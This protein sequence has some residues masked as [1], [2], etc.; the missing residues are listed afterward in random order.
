MKSEFFKV[1]ILSP[2]HIGSG[3]TVDAFGY[4]VEANGDE[5]LCHFV[6]TGAWAAEY[7]DPEALAKAYSS[8]SVA[9]MRAFMVADLDPELYAERS[10]RVVNNDLIR[11]FQAK[12]IDPNNQLL[13]S[14]NL[15][16]GGGGPLLPG[17][18]LKGA[19]RTAVIDW[20][21]REQGLNLKQCR[22]SREQGEKLERFIGKITDNS[23]Q[24]LKVADCEA[25]LGTS[26]VVMAKE[27]RRNPDKNVTPKADCEVL[28]SRLLGDQPRAALATR[29][30][31]GR[32]REKSS[33]LSLKNGQSLDWLQLCELVNNYSRT[34]YQKEQHKFWNLEHFAPTQQALA[35]IEPLILN[36][37]AGAMVLKVGHYSQ[38]EYVTVESNKPQTRRAKDG[39][40]LP[41]GTT[42]TLA[43]G[44]YP[45]GWVLLQPCNED[46]YRQLLNERDSHNS[47]LRQQQVQKR[48]ARQKA[49]AEK[50]EQ[51]R[52]R[53]AE[54][55]RQ[56]REREEKAREEAAKPWLAAVRRLSGQ[57]DWG[58][59]KQ[60]LENEELAKYRNQPEFAHAVL[61]TAE[62]LR[63]L[64]PDK[65]TDDRHQQVNDWLGSCGLAMA[66]TQEEES[67]DQRPEDCTL[68]E[69]LNEFGDFQNS[70]I[71][72]EELT[73][74]ALALL[75]QKMKAWGCDRRKAKKNKANAYQK[76]CMLMQK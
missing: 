62:K 17:S 26:L 47:T 29:I 43:D 74:E 21:D 42:R 66:A 11:K 41:H 70:T 14:P 65:W 2:V 5:G 71:K 76:V 57:S 39:G 32:P 28:A 13:L 49:A 72:L 69:G 37:P 45:F 54:Q 33:T 40:N 30:A 10:C 64:R 25:A 31:V 15:I 18:S 8:G 56:K 12:K 67:A 63:S 36:P 46:E 52:I 34:R 27:V 1:D 53:L 58:M 59:L 16:G 23:F 19:I 50:R 24:G 61:D 35:Q 51:V 73:P 3:D 38:I 4:L 6:D 9:D 48:A 20:L 60:L 22:N 44:I 75:E 7:P 55:E 68:I